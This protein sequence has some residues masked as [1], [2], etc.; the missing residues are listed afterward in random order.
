M[1]QKDLSEQLA[2]NRLDNQSI[3]KVRAD[4][5]LM[6]NILKPLVESLDSKLLKQEDIDLINS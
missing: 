5:N 4:G 3:K 6:Q 2:Q 1:K